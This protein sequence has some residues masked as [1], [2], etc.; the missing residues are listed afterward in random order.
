MTIRKIILFVVVLLLF[1]LW[2]YNWFPYVPI[3]GEV[4]I[5]KIVV[6]KSDRQ[7]LA[8]SNGNIIRK[9]SI[10]LGKAPHGDK[11]VEGDF[12]TPEGIYYINSKNPK[13]AYYKNLGISYPNSH[14]IREANLLGKKAG[15]DIKIH[16]IKNGRGFLRRFHRWIDWTNGC[17]ALTNEEIDD[18]YAHTPIGTPIQIKP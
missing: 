14:D 4:K 7:L 3:P 15:G 5:D 2:L 10:S 17:I 1:S 11:V 18:L 6:L 8:Y 13:S 16:G 9:F 12:K